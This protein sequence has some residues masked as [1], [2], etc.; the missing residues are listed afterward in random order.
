MTTL[1]VL[2]A[3]LSAIGVTTAIL[4]ERSLDATVDRTLAAAAQAE[5]DRLKEPSEGQSTDTE[6]ETEG[7]TTAPSGATPRA[8]EASTPSAS[9][10]VPSVTAADPDDHPPAAADTFFLHLDALGAVIA[11][12]ERVPLRGLPDPSAVAAATALGRDLRTIQA[13]GL[14]VRLLTI[15][16]SGD[17]ED[18]G[19]VRM[20]QAGFVLTLHDQQS[21]T[22]L[23]S[24]LIVGLGGLLGAAAVAIVLTR[25]ALA[26]VR[27]AIAH[28]R[29]FV[30]SAS[31]ELRTPIALIRSTSEVLA[32]EG[33]AAPDAAALI[34][35]ITAEAD[36]LAGLVTDLSELALAEARPPQ[37]AADIDLAELAV[38]V[39]HRA[40]PLSE[41]AGLRLETIAGSAV[42]AR[43]VRNEVVQ[44]TLILIDNAIRHTPTG[45]RVMITAAYRG[46]RPELWVTDEGPG[47]P[48]A[49]RER[50]FEPFARLAGGRG[51]AS[52]ERRPDSTPDGGSGLG[53]AI[54]RSLV[55]GMGGEI[56]VED[57]PGRGARFVVTLPRS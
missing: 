46:R 37:P 1:I 53:L 49:A 5:L 51:P 27:D 2:F 44:V 24:I 35:D 30:A 22:L 9:A 15:A 23:G 48:E 13:G 40:Q 25:R 38:D 32:R 45:G 31:H 16:V 36:R 47:I 20:I 56:R 18:T 17:G 8:G 50:I 42:R 39:A 12:P 7:G 52:R 3:L 19:Q 33:A 21:D 10:T 41:A 6:T 26:P 34:A 29:R 11:N 43:G 55:I 28:E 57:G 4:A 54:A 14:R